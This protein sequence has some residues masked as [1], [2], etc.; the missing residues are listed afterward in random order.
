[1]MEIKAGSWYRCKDGT[2]GKIHEID[3][4]AYYPVR[5]SIY[6]NAGIL[7]RMHTAQGTRYDDDV[8]HPYDLEKEINVF[9]V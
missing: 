9:N 8:G 1:M 6:T 3:E 5:V 4:Q 2:V 7:L